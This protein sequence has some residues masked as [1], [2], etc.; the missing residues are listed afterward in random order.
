M[1]VIIGKKNKFADRIDRFETDEED[2]VYDKF[3]SPNFKN[4]KEY[5]VI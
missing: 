3:T 1:N 2:T 4:A 5:K